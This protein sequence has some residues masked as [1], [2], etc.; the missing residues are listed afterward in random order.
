MLVDT[1][2]YFSLET[3]RSFSYKET[4]L[5]WIESNGIESNRMRIEK[6]ETEPNRVES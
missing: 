3:D 5:N 1:A 6:N 2:N 4:E